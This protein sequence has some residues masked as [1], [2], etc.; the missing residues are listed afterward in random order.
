[1]TD[2]R[3]DTLN[4]ESDKPMHI[5][6]AYLDGHVWTGGFNYLRNLLAAVHSLEK[7]ERPEIALLVPAEATPNDYQP[8]TPC[9]DRVLTMPREPSWPWTLRRWRT[10]AREWLGMAPTIHTYLRAQSV[11][12]LFSMEEYG[13]YFRMP[14]LTWIPDFQHCRLPEM[15]PEEERK[16]RDRRYARI[17]RN[18]TRVIV[19]SRDALNDLALVAPKAVDKAR[20]L[21]FVAQVPAGLY[22]SDPTWVC[23][24]Y[25]L[26]RRFFYLPNQFWKHKNHLV[27]L[28]AL[29]LLHSRRP[30]ITVVCTGDTRD[31]RHSQYFAQLQDRIAETG[32]ND[33]LVILGKVPHEDV[34]QLMRQSVAVLQPSLFEGWSTLVEEAKSIGKRIIIS[35]IPVHREQRPPAAVFFDPRNA[36]ALAGC[37]EE[38]AAS[39]TAGPDIELEAHARDRLPE[40]ARQFGMALVQIVREA[41]EL[42]EGTA[43]RVPEVSAEP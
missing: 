40:R 24:R 42:E 12:C 36:E 5:A 14:L 25:N 8:L 39:Y 16:E 23:E 28:Q 31:Y 4:G 7:S 13:P 32:L 21:S 41:V 10:S 33:N 38:A 29:E 1:M 6:F 30:E 17:A 37:L 11:T 22:N 18:A 15:F 9:V 20:V 27:V 43:V 2:D 3:C 34:L 35:D 26:P 19:S